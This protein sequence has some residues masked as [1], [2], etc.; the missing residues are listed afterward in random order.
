MREST[1]DEVKATGVAWF[2]TKRFGNPAPILRTFSLEDATTAGLIPAKPDATWSKY[3]RRMLFQRARGWALRDAYP[4]VL[5]GISIAEEV[6]DMPEAVLPERP[7]IQ[8]PRAKT[9]PAAPAPRS[10]PDASTGGLMVTGVST[11]SG[12]TKDGNPYKIHTV[13]FSD[14]TSADTFSE[15]VA[16]DAE[17]AKEDGVPVRISVQPNSNPRFAPSLKSLTL[18][19]PEPGAQG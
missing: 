8:Q 6:M 16:N 4:D 5:R 7:S 17:K 3:P 1:D 12:T 13:S 19:F 14:G 10:A 2:E 15:S 11:K 9:P 18:D